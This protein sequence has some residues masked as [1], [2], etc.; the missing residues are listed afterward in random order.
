MCVC[1]CALDIKDHVSFTTVKEDDEALLHHIYGHALSVF[2]KVTGVLW[3]TITQWVKST[4]VSINW[5]RITSL[6]LQ[7]QRPF[8]STWDMDAL[9]YWASPVRGRL[10]LFETPFV[11]RNLTEIQHEMNKLVLLKCCRCH[12]VKPDN[13][14][15]EPIEPGSD[16]SKV[17]IH[18]CSRC[19]REK[20]R[21]HRRYPTRKWIPRFGPENYMVPE[22]PPECARNITLLERWMI[23]PVASM[24]HIVMLEKVVGTRKSMKGSHIAFAQNIAPLT[25]KLP[26]RVEDIDLV[27]V[28]PKTFEQFCVFLFSQPK[29]L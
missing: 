22:E 2:S 17:T 3:K 24:A 9:I 5:F 14:H 8:K 26:K 13:T 19:V 16:L 21:F 29:Y 1:V 23:A 25:K 27:I 15:E 28:V 4:H 18:I 10:K 11:R 7:H 12:E 20:E 6:T